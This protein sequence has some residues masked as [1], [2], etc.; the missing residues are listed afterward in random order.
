MINRTSKKK[1]E[2]N[3]WTCASGWFGFHVE[4]PWK[5]FVSVKAIVIDEALIL[6]T[7]H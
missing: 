5:N 2:T 6:E 3:F 4:S 1:K 7:I